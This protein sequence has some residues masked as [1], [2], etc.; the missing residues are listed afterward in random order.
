MI[1]YIYSTDFDRHGDLVAGMF[2]DRT[3]Q[4]R[5]RMHWDVTVDALGWETDAYDALDPLYVIAAD[6]QGRHMGSMRFLPTTGPTML[7]EVFPHLTGG[8]SI[9]SPRVWECTRFCLS[10]KAGSGVARQ[11]LLAA[12]ELGLGLG[13]TH[14]VGVFDA[15]MTRVYRRLGWQPEVLGTRDGI[16]AGVWTFS[17]EVHDRLLGLVGIHPSQSRNDFERTFASLLHAEPLSV[18]A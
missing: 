1:H 5:D 14:S 4:F 18:R 17:E 10:P 16:S 3:A 11:L 8:G 15:P 6:G 13:L 9:R 2:R 7:G 12:S